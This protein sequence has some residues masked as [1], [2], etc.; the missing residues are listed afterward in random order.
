MGLG[1]ARQTVITYIAKCG[2]E[3]QSKLAD[4]KMEAQ[5]I[6]DISSRP[7]K[8]P[9]SYFSELARH[10]HFRVETVSRETLG[11]E[12]KK[13][14]LSMHQQTF[15][16]FPYDF[17]DKLEMMLGQP[18]IYPMV[19]AKSI[20]G[21]HVYAFSNLEL[22]T[23]KLQDGSRLRLAEF[24]NSM[25]VSKDKPT[26]DLCCLQLK[27]VAHIPREVAEAVKQVIG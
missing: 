12:D 2:V 18:D 6:D 16:T 5:L 20:P 4:V 13:Q 14:L 23:V 27:A 1:D 26:A 24:D 8:G 22:N 7:R 19:M 10:G 17:A 3:R 9:T 21:N 25:R 11:S 15:P